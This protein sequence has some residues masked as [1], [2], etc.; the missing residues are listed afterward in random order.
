[1]DAID[2]EAK[3]ADEPKLKDGSSEGKAIYEVVVEV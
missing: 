1:V 3:M 2:A